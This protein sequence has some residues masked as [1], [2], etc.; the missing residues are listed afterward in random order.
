MADPQD[1]I[2][3]NM[4]TSD[5]EVDKTTRCKYSVASKTKVDG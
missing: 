2:A 3:T 1:I 5:S 4:L